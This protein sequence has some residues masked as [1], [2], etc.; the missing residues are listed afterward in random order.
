MAEPDGLPA[1]ALQP[2]V[3]NWKCNLTY[4]IVVWVSNGTARVH[5]EET[6]QLLQAGQALWIP[7]FIAHKVEHD[8]HCLALSIMVRTTSNHRLGD[9]WRLINVPPAQSQWMFHL[10]LLTLSPLHQGQGSCQGLAALA[11]PDDYRSSFSST[12]AESTI[13]PS[14]L[15]PSFQH[16]SCSHK[17][18]PSTLLGRCHPMLTQNA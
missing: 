12:L 18:R 11:Q 4:S 13:N 7:R 9:G 16:E 5:F 14:L 3:V 6:V 10:M 1:A 2:V 17:L 15:K 8:A